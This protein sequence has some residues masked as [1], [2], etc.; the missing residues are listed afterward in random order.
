MNTTMPATLN[1]AIAT[2][3]MWLQAWVLVMVLT[4][5]LAVGFVAGREN[6]RWVVR[7]E[8]LAI[9]ASFLLASVLMT[10]IYS[11]AGYVRLLGLA[12]LVF[13]T[14]AW[15]WVA[16][17][18]RTRGLSTLFGKYLAFYLV[19]AGLSLV[20]DAVDVVRYLLGDGELLNR[21]G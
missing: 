15:I 1:E 8:A 4:H 19:I 21:H 7:Y 13:W 2:E 5:F 10:W 11:Q 14:P 9:L 16:I 12:H 17:R 6:D 3:P 20:I 18:L